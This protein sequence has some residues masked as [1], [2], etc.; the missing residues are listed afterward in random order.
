MKRA[1]TVAAWF[2]LTLCISTVEANGQTPTASPSPT[3]TPS[4]S[5]I[6]VDIIYT[7]KLF[8]YFRSPSLQKIDQA[9]GCPAKS[10]AD[11]EAAKKFFEHQRKQNSILVATGDNFA[12]QLE[13][14]MFENPPQPAGGEY[15]AGNK[16]LFVFDDK[17][18]WITYDSK[19][20]S[21]SLLQRISDGYGTI[22][23][24]NVACFLRAAKF[25]AVV[26]GKHDFYFGPE[27]LRQLARFLATTNTANDS[28]PVQMLGANL[29]LKTS[30][31]ETSG[32]KAEQPGIGGWP[33]E[34]TVMNLKEGKTVYPWFTYVKIKLETEP[35]KD[36]RN[37]KLFLCLSKGGPNEIPEDFDKECEP[38]KDFKQ[39]DNTDVLYV[40]LPD[41]NSPKIRNPKNGHLFKLLAGKNYA[42]CT[43]RTPKKPGDPKRAACDSHRIRRSSIFHI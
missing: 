25:D 24:D 2:A 18:G 33:E 14:R 28:R 41:L 29:V 32:G 21:P 12:P 31:L 34:Y 38:L 6:E 42:L 11:S 4:P 23:T 37:K 13:A 10:D 27:R 1:L 8:G 20:A 36:V 7:G 26:P 30:S 3:A 43:A 16:E 39:V 19:N 5:P 15:A 9:K 40:K 22:P 35:E 17:T